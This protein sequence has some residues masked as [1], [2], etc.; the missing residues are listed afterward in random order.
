MSASFG[1]PMD[2]AAVKANL[3]G[4]SCKQGAQID[5]S[6]ECYRQRLKL[7][8]QKTP[9]TVCDEPAHKVN[10][11][12]LDA[13]RIHKETAVTCSSQILGLLNALTTLYK[14]P[15]HQVNAVEVADSQ[16]IHEETAA[17]RLAQIQEAK[18]QSKVPSDTESISTNEPQSDSELE[19]MPT[20]STFVSESDDVDKWSDGQS[21]QIEEK[22]LINH[23]FFH[24]D[25]KWPQPLAALPG[26]HF[27][28]R[29]RVGPRGG[30]ILQPKGPSLPND[31]STHN[32][33]DL[34]A[35]NSMYSKIHGAF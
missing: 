4:P 26:A 29:P 1:F 34:I 25:M 18:L 16:K 3:V 6:I 27:I 28:M 10:A 15:A 31:A 22:P 8:R 21:D 19:S 5:D 11:G 30:L 9:P 32:I 7:I 2:L 24:S 12:E 17:L 13:P 14:K 33:G 20:F 35:S 23:K